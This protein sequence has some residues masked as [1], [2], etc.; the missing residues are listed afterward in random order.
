M[1]DTNPA[2]RARDLLVHTADE[3]SDLYVDHCH[4]WSTETRAS[5]QLLIAVITKEVRHP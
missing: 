5:I 3:L 4:E 1:T 2:N